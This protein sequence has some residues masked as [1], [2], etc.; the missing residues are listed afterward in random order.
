MRASATKC[1]AALIIICKREL[2]PRAHWVGGFLLSNE[3][4]VASRLRDMT[5][6][7]TTSKGKYRGVLPRKRAVGAGSRALPWG[8]YL[9]CAPGN[10]GG[11]CGCL[12]HNIC[13]YSKQ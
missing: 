10:A 7:V 3:A 8:E 6:R 4:R 2:R 12:R 9:L 1:S 13:L 5:E 11:G